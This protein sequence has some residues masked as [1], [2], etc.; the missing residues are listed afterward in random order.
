MTDCSMVV[1]MRPV[2]IA[3]QS[4]QRR[5]GVGPCLHQPHDDIVSVGGDPHLVAGEG[6]EVNKTIMGKVY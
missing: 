3:W 2:H 6:D 5:D 4:G 1:S